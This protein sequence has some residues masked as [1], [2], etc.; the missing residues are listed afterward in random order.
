MKEINSEQKTLLIHHTIEVSDV[1]THYVEQG[2]KQPLLMVDGWFGSWFAFSRVIPLLAEDFR[3]LAVDLPGFGETSE[4]KSP[5]ITENYAKFLS[6]FLEVIGLEKVIYLGASY[7]A[8]VGIKFA[9]LYPERVGKLILQGVPDF[10]SLPR[11]VR[12]LLG[13]LPD[14]LSTKVFEIGKNRGVLIEKVVSFNPQLRTWGKG[15]GKRVAERARKASARAGIETINE[16]LDFDLTEAKK[17]KTPTLLVDG[18]DVSLSFMKTSSRL[19]KLMP[20]SR[21]V[22]IKEASHTLPGQKPKEFAEAIKSFIILREENNVA[23]CGI[24]ITHPTERD[25]LLRD[26]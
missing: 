10:S 15:H 9:S 24:N 5:H 25:K 19:H 6:S 14:N 23:S 17:I 20:K 11:V 4:L 7:G 16:L 21:L 22:L 12:R 3:C 18:A 13:V 8:L 1:K 26:E 2:K